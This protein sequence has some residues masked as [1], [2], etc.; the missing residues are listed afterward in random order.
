MKKEDLS[1]YASVRNVAEVE[2]FKNEFEI[3]LNGN[4]DFISLWESFFNDISFIGEDYITFNDWVDSESKSLL[5][6]P[7]EEDNYLI[8]PQVLMA[9]SMDDAVIKM[10]LIV[11]V[12]DL[13]KDILAKF[14]GD[15]FGF[16]DE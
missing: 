7:D 9:F 4:R 3:W 8:H 16:E 12:F 6:H 15:V 1:Y 14:L 10:N 5:R 11:A 13:P 2:P